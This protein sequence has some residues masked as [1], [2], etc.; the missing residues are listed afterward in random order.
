[1]VNTHSGWDLPFHFHSSRF[2]DFHHEKFKS[3]CMLSSAAYFLSAR[4]YIYIHIDGVL[5]IL[6]YLHGTD[7][8]FYER[9]HAGFYSI[10]I[11]KDVQ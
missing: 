2:H 9:Y 3:N 1:M 6:D 7:G 11:K 10:L 4:A 8:G 5:G